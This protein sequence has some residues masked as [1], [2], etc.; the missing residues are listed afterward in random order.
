ML[1][2]KENH[3]IIT[4]QTAVTTQI[5]PLMTISSTIITIRIKYTIIPYTKFTLPPKIT[6][7]AALNNRL[8]YH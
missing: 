1:N 4:Y 3:R 5:K 2:S 7:K 8:T 6:H